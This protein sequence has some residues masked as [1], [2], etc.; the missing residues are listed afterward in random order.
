[1][2]Q[3]ATLQLHYFP[4]KDFVY[5]FSIFASAQV[6]A[7]KM[8]SAL[9]TLFMPFSSELSLSFSPTLSIS[10]MWMWSLHN[11]DMMAHTTIL[12]ILQYC[13]AAMYN[14]EP[15]RQLFLWL[16]K[17]FWWFIYLFFQSPSVVLVSLPWHHTSPSRP[18]ADFLSCL[19]G[20][21]WGQRTL[22]NTADL[23]QLIIPPL[24]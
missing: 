10:L 16:Y 18:M 23:H 17:K 8:T 24:F 14:K 6:P 13:D 4:T 3:S 21:G 5:L 11:Q 22:T 20:W 2:T 15:T 1:M 7:G 9:L 12:L 19:G